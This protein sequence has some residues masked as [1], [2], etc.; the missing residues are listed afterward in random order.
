M[1]GYEHAL[2]LLLLLGFLLRNLQGRH[3]ISLYL[4]VGGLL[5]VLL[6]PIVSVKIPWNLILAFVLPWILW[7]NSRNWLQI[8]RN[9]PRKE[10]CLW[11][12]TALSLVLIVVFIGNIAW[13]RAIFFGIVAASLL[14]QVSN[15]GEISN[16]LEVIGPL[17]LVFLLVETSLPVDAPAL[18]FG[19]LFSG[20]GIGIALVILSIAVVKKVP[21]KYESWILLGQVYLA[22]WIALA[23]NASPIAAVLISVVVFA[24]FHYTHLEGKEA[25]MA[26]ARL[27][28]RLPFFILL[29]LFIFT[30]WQTHQP[31]TLIQWFEVILGLCTGLLVA[32]LG[33]RIGLPRFEHLSS[34]WRSALKLGL[35]LFGILILW[36]RGSE[37]RPLLI[38]VALGLAVFLPVLSAILLATLRDLS[39]QQNRKKTDD[40]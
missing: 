30:A 7:R 8:A 32:L 33:Q 31:L 23:L 28:D 22:Y 9:F 20:A 34:N 37:L 4:M 40:F 21:P 10:I 25:I 38:W 15:R 14:W 24:E 6:P 27:D 1:A 39:T 3:P 35:F 19:S 26:S 16:P 36:P 5:L 11:L 17:T 13:F 12:I 29:T 2:F 18:Y